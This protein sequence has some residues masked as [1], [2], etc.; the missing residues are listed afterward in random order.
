MGDTEEMIRVLIVDDEIAVCRLIEYLVPWKQL[1]MT[2]VGYA[3]NGPESLPADPGE[4][5]GYCA[6]GYSDAWIR[7]PGIN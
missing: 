7:R 6:Y 3:N 4:A 1:K 5:A 2:S